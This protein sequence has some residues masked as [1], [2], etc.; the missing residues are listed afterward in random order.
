MVRTQTSKGA[1]RS[2]ASFG[3]RW[4]PLGILVVLWA[5][6]SGRVVSTEVLPPPI[7]VFQKTISLFVTGQILVHLGISLVRVTLGLVLGSIVGVALGI[8]MARSDPIENFFDVFLTLTYPVPKTALVPLAIL[9]LGTGTKSV[10][11]VVFLGSLL[12]IVL[13]AYNAAGDV[14]K[15]LIWSARSMGTSERDVLRKV[16]FPASIP[17]ITTGIRQAIPIGFIV[18]VSAEL[19]AADV[20]VGSVI[21]QYGSLGQYRQMFAVILIISATAYAGVRGFE[22]VQRRVLEWT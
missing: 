14:Q 20:G 22:R 1:L 13:N 3:F 5:I 7:G 11:F 9:W 6:A 17:Q 8:G 4:L 18:L 12:P 19:I 2:V 15:E 21:L 10:V 16:V